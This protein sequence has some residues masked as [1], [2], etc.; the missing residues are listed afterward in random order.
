MKCEICHKNE[1]TIHI[2]EITNNG[3]KKVNLCSECVLNHKLSNGISDI[4]INEILKKFS[5]DFLNSET[6][7]LDIPGLPFSFH[8]NC[9]SSVSQLKCPNCGW[10]GVKLK[11]YGRL[12]CGKCYHIFK[13]ILKDIIKDL[14]RDSVHLGKRPVFNNIQQ[15]EI[16]ARLSILRKELDE[17]VKKEKYEQAALIRDKIN[18]LKNLSKQEKK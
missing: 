7:S 13:H 5:S 16:V 11:K 6:P 15:T 2:Q 4:D 18:D 3:K 10:D 8:E 9:D 14:H 1:A 12:G 17:Y